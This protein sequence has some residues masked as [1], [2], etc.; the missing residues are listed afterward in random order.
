MCDLEIDKWHIGI[1]MSAK[2]T[3]EIRD[4]I[5]AV[6]RGKPVE[7]V[8]LFGSAARGEIAPDSDVDVLITPSYDASRKMLLADRL[9]L[10][11]RLALQ[12]MKRVL[13]RACRLAVAVWDSLEHFEGYKEL[14][15]LIERLHGEQAAAALRAAF[16]LRDPRLLSSLCVEAGITEARVERQEGTARFPSLPAWF[17]TEVKGWVLA[18]RLDDAQFEM[19]LKD[20]QE[21]LR[22]F[23]AADGTV[24]LRAPAYI[25]TATKTSMS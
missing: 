9:T 12:E 20:G 16:S 22:P 8:D 10:Y 3:T 4:V 6:L 21:S 2:T 24:V 14:I 18:D 1:E 5:R 15:A 23:V 17:L 11:Q 7:Q 19:L 25:I 13:R